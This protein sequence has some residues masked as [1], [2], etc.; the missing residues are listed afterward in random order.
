MLDDLIETDLAAIEA[1]LE[2]LAPRSA[3]PTVRQQPKRTALPADFP[4]T[5]IHYYPESTQCQ[6]GCALKRIGEDVSEKLDYTQGVL[7]VERH[8]RGKWV[9][10]CETLIQESVPAQVIDKGTPT[11]GL[12]VQV[13]IAKYADHLPLYRQEQIFGRAGLAI[14]RSTLANWVGACGVQLRHWSMSRATSCLSTTWCMSMKRRCRC[15]R[16][17]IRKPNVLM[18]GA[19]PRRRSPRSAPWCTTSAQVARASMPVTF[20]ATGKASWSAT[21]TVVTKPV[22]HLASPKS[23]A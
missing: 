9:C 12:L 23:A 18:F 22:L 6:C 17:A 7:S 20:L 11:A 10:D 8:I 15:S 14:P 16:R 3:Q 4:R 5:L 19:M 2:T 1:E 21:I 13:M